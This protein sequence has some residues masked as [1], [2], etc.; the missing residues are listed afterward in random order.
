MVQTII[1]QIC[2]LTA[3]ITKDA[4]LVRKDNLLDDHGEEKIPDS[5]KYGY[6]NIS[7]QEYTNKRVLEIT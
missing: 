4:L 2:I 3:Q 7:Y 6:H 1:N 5:K